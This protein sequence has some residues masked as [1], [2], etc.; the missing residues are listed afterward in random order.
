[1]SGERHDAYLFPK[2]AMTKHVI[3][4]VIGFL[5]GGFAALLVRS[6]LHH[7]FAGHTGHP[8]ATPNG[9]ADGSAA[10]AASAPASPGKGGMEGMEGMNHE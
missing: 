5:I 3:A 8:I 9:A 2:V 10:P 1:M 7:P 4:C 6:A